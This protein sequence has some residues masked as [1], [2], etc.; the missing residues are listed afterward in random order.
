MLRT[1]SFVRVRLIGFKLTNWP[2]LES[3]PD[4]ALFFDIQVETTEYQVER[5]PGRIATGRMH[6]H[7]RDDE[8]RMRGTRSRQFDLTYSTT[9]CYHNPSKL[10]GLEV[11]VPSTLYSV[12]VVDGHVMFHP[13]EN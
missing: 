10:A 12:D 2:V 8:T 5:R 4:K 7:F 1:L 13:K 3:R 11:Y 9:Q 6:L